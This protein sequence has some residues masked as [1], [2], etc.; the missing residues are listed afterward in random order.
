MLLQAR[1]V[2]RLARGN[3]NGALAD[4]L[5]CGERME[6]LGVRSPSLLPW[7]GLA[8]EA[9]LL[10]GVPEEA[11]RLAVDEVELAG[12]LCGPVAQAN[13]TRVLGLAVG[14]PAGLDLLHAAA[15][16]VAGAPGSL[17]QARVSTDLGAALRR[18]GHAVDAREHLVA[19]LDAADACGAA[20]LA[21]R[22]RDELL[23][24][25]GRPRRARQR[26]PEALTPSEL[27]VARLAAAGATNTVIAQTLF[28]S[29]K[30]VEKHLASAYRKLGV[31]SR[32]DLDL[33]ALAVRAN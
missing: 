29:R 28:V 31:T 30:T 17:V 5:T 14:G 6:R 24:A 15:E 13:A 21:Q 3:A 19:A 23:A 22:A 12:R 16:Q 4:L 26:G 11:R 10:L 9:N 27:R 2:F 33:T 1:A 25:G 18:S 8:A 7:R 32:A 20:P